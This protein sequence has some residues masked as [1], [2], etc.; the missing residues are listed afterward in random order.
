[1]VLIMVLNDIGNEVK[2]ITNSV[3]A[4]SMYA[5]TRESRHMKNRYAMCR[6]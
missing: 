2:T 4:G 3:T 5:V 6:E 1:M